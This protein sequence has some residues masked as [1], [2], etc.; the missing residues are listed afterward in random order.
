MTNVI[1][2]HTANNVSCDNLVHAR[3]IGVYADKF[4]SVTEMGVNLSLLYKF[5]LQKLKYNCLSW[6]TYLMRVRG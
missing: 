3:I 1:K 5:L 4:T 2:H 6:Q